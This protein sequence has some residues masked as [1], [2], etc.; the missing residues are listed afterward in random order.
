VWK[1]GYGLKWRRKREDGECAASSYIPIDADVSLFWQD[2]ELQNMIFKK[3][4]PD[5]E[6]MLVSQG[7]LVTLTFSSIPRSFFAGCPNAWLW[8][9]RSEIQ[10][11]V[12]CPSNNLPILR[13]S[14]EAGHGK[15]LQRLKYNTRN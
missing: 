11:L 15:S 4:T 12:P 5:A 3:L 8:N 2:K 10:K 9:D 6:I 7:L 1:S 13:G 14:N